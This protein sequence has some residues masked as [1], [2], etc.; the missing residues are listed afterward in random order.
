M[1][2]VTILL[3]A[4][5][6]VS[7]SGMARAQGYEDIHQSSGAAG[8]R[9]P[10]EI[11][12]D[13]Q[14]ALDG[15][16]ATLGN[17]FQKD[18]IVD[19]EEDQQLCA[20]FESTNARVESLW[21][22]F[23]NAV[24]SD[25]EIRQLER[26]EAFRKSM[27]DAY[28]NYRNAFNVMT[29][30]PTR[31]YTDFL[32][33]A[34]MKKYTLARKRKVLGFIPWP[35]KKIHLAGGVDGIS[36]WGGD[37]TKWD[38]TELT[39][40]I[41]LVPGEM[42][43]DINRSVQL[44]YF[45]GYMYEWYRH[46]RTHGFGLG[47]DFA[48]YG[49][50]SYDYQWDDYYYYSYLQNSRYMYSSLSNQFDPK[51]PRSGSGESDLQSMA[52]VVADIEAAIAEA[53]A[54]KAKHPEIFIEKGE[55]RIAHNLDKNKSEEIMSAYESIASEFQSAMDTYKVYLDNFRNNFPG[56]E[57]LVLVHFLEA[58]ISDPGAVIR[59]AGGVFDGTIVVG[60]DLGRY[61]V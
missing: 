46:D 35:A 37:P 3:V 45:S 56:A 9:G 41:G 49:S 8:A 18:V 57:T 13:I 21:D 47:W 30:D 38:D 39:Y 36:N 24:N 31:K 32:T 25:V 53:D 54:F 1:R 51:Q 12:N 10:N 50:L 26:D 17:R 5:M 48:S 61:Q 19:T 4:M 23:F 14:A 40:A 28:M 7:I 44:A 52:E 55:M 58:T 6:L 43:T 33:K 20:A 22:E 11:L 29:D 27:N 59:E 2:K 42:L 60:E 34:K 16:K 15:L